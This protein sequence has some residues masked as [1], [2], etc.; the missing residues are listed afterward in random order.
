MKVPTR[1]GSWSGR[2]S[3]ERRPKMNFVRSKLVGIRQAL[4]GSGKGRA[5]RQETGAAA[6]LDLSAHSALS[7]E[8]RE[9]ALAVIWC[10]VR[11]LQTWPGAAHWLTM[12]RNSVGSTL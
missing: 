2:A 10:G 3:Q 7:A 12:S 11:S 1:I 9:A 5:R 8:A 4:R 6:G